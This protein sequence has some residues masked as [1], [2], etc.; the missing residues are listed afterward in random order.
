MEQHVLQVDMTGVSRSEAKS[1]SSP[2]MRRSRGPVLDTR[3]TMVRYLHVPASQCG[4]ML[5]RGIL[6]D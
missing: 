6:G 4:L 5:G 3:Q 2:F 1:R